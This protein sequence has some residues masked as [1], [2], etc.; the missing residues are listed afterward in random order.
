MDCVT[1][2]TT[3]G[4]RLMVTE[5]NTVYSWDQNMRSLKNSFWYQASL[6][7]YALIPGMQL[8]GRWTLSETETSPF[9]IVSFDPTSGVSSPNADYWLAILHKR[10]VGTDMLAADFSDVDAGVAY[11]SCT[12]G[13]NNGSVTVAYAMPGDF[14]LRLSLP[15][16]GAWMEH[17]LYALTEDTARPAAGVNLNDVPLVVTNDGSLPHLGGEFG[18]G[19]VLLPAQSVGFIVFPNAGAS[20]CVVGPRLV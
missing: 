20:A 10:L 8:H 6:G 13:S 19:E 2:G 12:R 9:S 7:Q 3:V 1:A 18:S 16:D 14:L 17:A 11:A 4:L 15:A 5:T